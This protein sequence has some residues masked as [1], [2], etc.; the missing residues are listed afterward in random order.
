MIEFQ[1]RLASGVAS[2]FPFLSYLLWPPRRC[3]LRL[4][5][6]I[7]PNLSPS[8]NQYDSCI[9]F[10]QQVGFAS[11]ESGSVRAKN[12]RNVLLKVRKKRVVFSTEEEGEREGRR[13]AKE[14]KETDINFDSLPSSKKQ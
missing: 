8:L 12:T 3:R 11:L 14:R 6:N 4:S 9:T 1:K 13:R 2:A 7:N 10:F 5:L